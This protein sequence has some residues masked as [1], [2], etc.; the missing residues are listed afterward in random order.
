MKRFW[1]IVI[2][3]IGI[4][5]AVMPISLH[6][7]LLY[8]WSVPTLAL[9]GIWDPYRYAVEQYPQIA[10]SDFDVYYPPLSYVAMALLLFVL[11]PFSSTLVPWLQRSRELIF[12][13]KDV[14]L[15]E[16][17]DSISLAELRM[18][19]LLLKMPSLLFEV[20]VLWALTQLVPKEKKLLVMFLWLFNPLVI[21]T[22]YL[23]G[24]IDMITVSFILLALVISKKRH[25]FTSLFMV[26]LG[27]MVKTLPLFLIPPFVFWTERSWIRRF[28]LGV[29]VLSSFFILNIPWMKEFSRLRI[30]YF[31]SVMSSVLDMSIR[32][33]AIIKIAVLMVSIGIMVWFCKQ[34]FAMK[35]RMAQQL[36]YIIGAFLMLFFSAY[37]GI[38]VNHWVIVLPFLLLRW[39]KEP[40]VVMKSL[41]F[42]VLVFA[43]QV[44][45][46]PL[47]S[48]LFLPLGIES[49][50]S[51]PSTREIL[52]PVMK[53]EHISL[54][55]SAV[56]SIWM[57]T[58]VIRTGKAFS[59][60]RSNK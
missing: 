56:L 8:V 29:L 17:I 53:Y 1:L 35:N 51:F 18:N 42:S 50:F 60:G 12:S 40:R 58:E 14:S 54:V 49:I 9:Q 4:R 38:L 27:S 26:I 19:I 43:T 20:I 21:Y 28:T 11:T 59:Y 24:Q 34:M 30:A 22:G 57:L 32:I 7:D 25:Q 44:Y 47:Q 10:R 46:K 31:P 37:R 36:P 5:L 41:V 52:S 48:G 39:M 33:D 15:H 45:T 6:G 16:Y 23:L 55:T 13:L 2:L 3:A